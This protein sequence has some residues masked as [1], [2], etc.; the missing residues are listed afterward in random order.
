MRLVMLFVAF[1]QLSAAPPPQVNE[2]S[3]PNFKQ[4]IDYVQWYK[5]QLRFADKDNAYEKYRRFMVP[6]QR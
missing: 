2:P 3:P 1:I 4:R 6:K 5:D